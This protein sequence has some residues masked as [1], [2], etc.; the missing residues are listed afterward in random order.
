MS[1]RRWARTSPRSCVDQGYECNEGRC[2]PGGKPA[3]CNN[4]AFCQIVFSGQL[5]FCE[6]TAECGT[7][8]VCVALA[9]FSQGSCPLLPDER[10]GCPTDA[11]ETA[12]LPLLEG[13]EAEVCIARDVF[14]DPVGGLAPFLN[15]N[16][17]PEPC[18]SNAECEKYP[19]QPICGADGGCVC[20][21]D[22]HCADAGPHA[23]CVE[24]RCACKSDQDCAGLVGADTCVDGVCGCGSPAVASSVPPLVGIAVVVEPPDPAVVVGRS[25]V[26]LASPTELVT[27]GSLALAAGS[28]TQPGDPAL[29]HRRRSRAT[30]RGANRND[31]RDIVLL[32][33]LPAA[34]D[35]PR[36]VGGIDRLIRR[37]D[38]SARA[39]ATS[40][41]RTRRCG[42]NWRR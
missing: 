27:M 31:T 7:G 13:G 26:V 1:L 6:S 14:C 33:R 12:T 30:G 39:H 15:C 41:T 35:D 5:I 25:A 28:P 38:T 10:G 17:V 42:S 8:R 4:D 29:T 34:A 19:T 16:L 3:E 21:S 22:D 37:I 40:S 18:R 24:G 9:G 23:W 20:D 11:Y 2:R 36:G 32:S